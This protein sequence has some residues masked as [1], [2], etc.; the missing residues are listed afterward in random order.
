M[1]NP[2]PLLLLLPQV[3]VSIADLVNLIN[4]KVFIAYLHQLY[5]ISIQNIQSK[6]ILSDVDNIIQHL[7][8]Q[9]Y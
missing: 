8:Q 7:M 4:Y 3:Q 1:P 9:C 6:L 2:L 5:I